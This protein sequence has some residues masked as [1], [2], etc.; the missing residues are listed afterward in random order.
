MNNHRQTLLYLIADGVF[1]SGEALSSALGVSRTAVNKSIHQ[2]RQLGLE[3]ESRHG[4]GYK[5]AS[6]LQL[7]DKE[8]IR[9][10]LSALAAQQC[11]EIEIL[12][13]A[14]STNDYLAD[15][16]QRGPCSGKVVIAEY[17]SHGKGRRGNQ[18]VSPVGS[19]LYLS[20]AW[21]AQKSYASI[22]LLSLFTGVAVVRVLSQL[23][24]NGPCLKW[25][26]PT[27]LSM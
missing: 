17:Q 11:R 27:G 22:G 5:L 21:Q 20:L 7:L 14:E 15:C 13:E 1:H 2:L 6:P 26:R 25:P 4:R 12:F 24:V 8:R 10:G 18:W 19:G 3:I 9:S 16:I 23:G